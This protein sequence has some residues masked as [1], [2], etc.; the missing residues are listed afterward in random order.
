MRARVSATQLKEFAEKHR[1]VSSDADEL[2]RCLTIELEVELGCGL[3]VIPVCKW[4]EFGPTERPLRECNTPDGD[5][6]T[7][8]LSFDA[9]LLRDRFGGRDNATRD[10][11]SSVV[12]AFVL[13]RKHKYRVAFTDIFAAIHR[14]L[15]G[16]GKRQ[17]PRI[18]NLGFDC[19]CHVSYPAPMPVSTH[20]LQ[21]AQAAPTTAS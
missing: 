17:G 4:F 2:V 21:G 12:S 7:R 3:A 10:K 6:Y 14:L 15:R 20:H 1:R 11:T 19:E 18:V 8:C 5:T 9:G 16:E 13:A